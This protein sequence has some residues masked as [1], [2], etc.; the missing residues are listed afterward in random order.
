MLWKP[1]IA[2][3]ALF[4]AGLTATPSTAASV[5]TPPTPAADSLRHRWTIGLRYAGA[6]NF[7]G[8]G[9]FLPTVSYQWHPRWAVE[10]GASYW[11]GRFQ[12]SSTGFTTD[13]KQ[14][15]YRFQGQSWWSAV[16][17]RVRYT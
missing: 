4:G 14:V 13:G 17:V 1:I 10:L 15:D 5:P 11:R 16:P 12:G 6:P 7:Y 3:A 8:F 9:R 2:A